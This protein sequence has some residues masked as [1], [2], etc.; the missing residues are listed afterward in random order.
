MCVENSARKA[1]KNRIRSIR[2]C[3]P[4]AADWRGAMSQ[5]DHCAARMDNSQ[6]QAMRALQRCPL[7]FLTP[8]WRI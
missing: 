4:S 7:L 5:G 3:S 6:R 8:W 2:Q 1:L